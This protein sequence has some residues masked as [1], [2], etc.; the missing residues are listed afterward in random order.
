MEG[1]REKETKTRPGD[2][3]TA[4]TE[5]NIRMWE[6][7]GRA[8]TKTR[9]EGQQ[10]IPAKLLDSFPQMESLAWVQPLPE[11]DRKET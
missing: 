10:A 6:R 5:R 8:T 3:Q 7:A 11:D 4:R 2:K 1:E 9:S